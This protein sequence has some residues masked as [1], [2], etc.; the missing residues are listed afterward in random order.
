M[1]WTVQAVFLQTV[2]LA[3]MT[4]GLP[5]SFLQTTFAGRLL[6]RAI[7]MSRWVLACAILALRDAS[8]VAFEVHR[9]SVLH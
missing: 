7:V 4:L 6:G 3:G 5:M 8:V 2:F 1:S 9:I